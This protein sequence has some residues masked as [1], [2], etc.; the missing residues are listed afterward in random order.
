MNIVYC[1]HANRD[2]KGGMNENNGLT[3]LGKRDARLTARL[4]RT[5]SRWFLNMKRGICFKA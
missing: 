2:T 4:L 3:R 1:H 5:A